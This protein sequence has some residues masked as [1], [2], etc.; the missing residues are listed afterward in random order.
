MTFAWSRTRMAPA[1][2]L[3]AAV[4][5]AYLGAYGARGDPTCGQGCNLGC[6][7][8]RGWD[9]ADYGV[10]YYYAESV[11]HESAEDW[12]T[13]STAPTMGRSYN[14][15]MVSYQCYEGFDPDCPYAEGVNWVTGTVEGNTTATSGSVPIDTKCYS[16]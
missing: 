10:Y 15:K 9:R 11:A 14:Q 13:C 12:H 3:L 16:Y 7:T 8:S 2:A 1:V 5:I 4:L 6:G